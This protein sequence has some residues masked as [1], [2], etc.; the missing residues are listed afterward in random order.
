VREED[1]GIRRRLFKCAYLENID[2]KKTLSLRKVPSGDIKI[3]VIQ[4]AMIKVES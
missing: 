4:K 1:E 3:T 2:K